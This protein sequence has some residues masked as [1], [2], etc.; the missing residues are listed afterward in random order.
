MERFYKTDEATISIPDLEDFFQIL[1]RSE[2]GNS[3]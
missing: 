1:V 3:V 2:N